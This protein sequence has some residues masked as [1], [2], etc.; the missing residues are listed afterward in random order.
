MVSTGEGIR[1]GDAKFL[2]RE[3]FE[4]YIVLV[5]RCARLNCYP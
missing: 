5:S 3:F 1:E 4:P 2:P